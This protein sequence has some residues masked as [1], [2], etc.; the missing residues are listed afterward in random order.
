MNGINRVGPQT[1]IQP[2]FQTQQTAQQA[3]AQQS[4]PMDALANAIAALEKALQSLSFNTSGGSTSG[5]GTSALG[6][7]GAAK[8]NGGQGFSDLFNGSSLWDQPA[9]QTTQPQTTTQTDFLNHKGGGGGTVDTQADTKQ[10]DHGRWSENFGDKK[11]GG[12][13]RV[14]PLGANN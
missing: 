4:S 11:S 13:G 5:Q 14:D 1:T 8:G 3:P 2:S 12:G 7:S 9:Q 10:K 6:T